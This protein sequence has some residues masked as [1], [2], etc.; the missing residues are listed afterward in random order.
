MCLSKNRWL[1]LKLLASGLVKNHGYI[2]MTIYLIVFFF[3]VCS[4]FVGVF[5]YAELLLKLFV[6]FT[7]V[8]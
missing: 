7:L 4:I 6:F 3:F 5:F 2:V 8:L 1:V